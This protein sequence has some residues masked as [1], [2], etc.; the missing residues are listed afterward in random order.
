MVIQIHP[1]KSEYVNLHPYALHLWRKEN[2]ND[3]VEKPKVNLL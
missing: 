1:A 3:Y 2:T